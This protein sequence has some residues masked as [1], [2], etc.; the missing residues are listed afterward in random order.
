MLR[1]LLLWGNENHATIHISYLVWAA[2]RLNHRQYLSYGQLN[3][4]LFSLLHVS[5]LNVGSSLVFVFIY[6]TFYKPPQTPC[7]TN[8]YI[9]GSII[10]T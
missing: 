6:Y 9:C 5:C 8:F 4:A 10:I 3:W 7:E 2:K 1:K